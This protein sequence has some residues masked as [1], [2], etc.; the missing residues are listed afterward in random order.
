MHQTKI[1]AMQETI[2]P[3]Q[4]AIARMANPFLLN[5]SRN[6]IYV[7]DIPGGSGLPPG[8]PRSL[9]AE[10]TARYFRSVSIR[11][12]IYSYGDEAGFPLSKYGEWIFWRGDGYLKRVREIAIRTFGSQH[13]FKKLGTM[14]EN[15]YDDG[16]IFAL[17]LN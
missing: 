7:L 11:Y 4:P 8:L 1:R 2:P 13:V 10:E 16:K 12:L 3:G 9:N 17:D 6:P 14:Y 15:L 5:F